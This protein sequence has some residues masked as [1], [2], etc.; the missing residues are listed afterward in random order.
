MSRL[1]LNQKIWGKV[2]PV[3]LRPLEAANK[4]ALMWPL[5]E[6]DVRQAV[7][8]QAILSALETTP[9][10]AS[11]AERLRVSLNTT[12][13]L[14][15]SR[16]YEFGSHKGYSQ[17]QRDVASLP[18]LLRLLSSEEVSHWLCSR[19]EDWCDR[20]EAED[21]VEEIF[22]TLQ[23]FEAHPLT[24]EALDA[25]KATRNPIIAHRLIEKANQSGSHALTHDHLNFLT[26]EAAKLCETISF[27]LTGE[28]PNYTA[29]ARE[30]KAKAKAFWRGQ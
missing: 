14:C 9:A 27:L 21:T 6:Q 1:G 13:A 5:V 22:D 15:L 18:F 7:I 26:E 30:E 20:E 11:T 4:I 3:E 24:L 16:L 17:D 28:M 19:A 29:L 10:P 12:Q 2:E 25:L 23:A 8:S